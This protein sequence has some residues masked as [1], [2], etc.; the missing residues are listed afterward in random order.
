LPARLE[1]QQVGPQDKDEVPRLR[2]TAGQV[3]SKKRMGDDEQREKHPR[4]HG[5]DHDYS[6]DPRK[7]D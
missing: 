2:E 4:Y 5:S 6:P 1:Q 7:V 3:D